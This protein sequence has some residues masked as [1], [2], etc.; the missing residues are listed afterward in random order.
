MTFIAYNYGNKY[1]A[2]YFSTKYKQRA[3][4]R[5]IDNQLER[6]GIKK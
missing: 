1:I 3:F 6:L 5:E 4:N 2:Q